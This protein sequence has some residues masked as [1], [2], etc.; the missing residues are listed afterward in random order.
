MTHGGKK[1]SVLA[2]TVFLNFFLIVLSWSAIDMARSPP[3]ETRAAVLCFSVGHLHG[4][5]PHHRQQTP[6]IGRPCRLHPWSTHRILGGEFPH[7]LGSSGAG[8]N[9]HSHLLCLV[10]PSTSLPCLRDPSCINPKMRP[11]MTTYQRTTASAKAHLHHPSQRASASIS[12]EPVGI[13]SVWDCF[14]WSQ[15]TDFYILD[16]SISEWRGE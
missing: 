14:L 4:S 13:W 9:I 6:S 10:R 1:V 5:D 11:R 16:N 3:A 15:T 2:L 7:L 12:K 8:S